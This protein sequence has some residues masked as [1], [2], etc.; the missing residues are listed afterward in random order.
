MWL[1]A[2]GAVAVLAGLWIA[3]PTVRTFVGPDFQP[4]RRNDDIVFQAEHTS[5]P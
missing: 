1:I 4:V 5:H 3:L 2:M